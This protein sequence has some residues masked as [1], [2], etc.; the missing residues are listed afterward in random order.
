[1]AVLQNVCFGVKQCFDHSNEE[2]V[3]KPGFP[4]IKIVFVYKEDEPVL[5]E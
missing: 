5:F 1:M 4:L 2:I 3:S